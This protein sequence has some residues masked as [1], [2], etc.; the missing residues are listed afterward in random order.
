[1]SATATETKPAETKPE[2]KPAEQTTAETKPAETK[3]AESAPATGSETAT[4]Q[5][6]FRAKLTKFSAAFGAVN[7]S[8]WAADGL[9]YEQALE[10]H[11]AAL[12]T[13]LTAEQ[14]KTKELETKLGAV[15]RGEEKPVSFSTN[16]KHEAGT[17]VPTKLVGLGKMA[18]FA[19]S[20]KLPGG[21]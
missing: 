11:S 21:K 2:E 1:M 6:E 8:Q 4:A 19:A 13:Q 20:L 10:K 7:G 16:E 3:P 12:A 9:T 5:T 15:P 18:K 17:N 14:T